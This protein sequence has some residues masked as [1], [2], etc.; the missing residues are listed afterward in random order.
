MKAPQ[1]HDP[2]NSAATP[3][4]TPREDAAPAAALGQPQEPTANAATSAHQPSGPDRHPASAGSD[5]APNDTAAPATAPQFGATA[6]ASASQPPFPTPA[7]ATAPPDRAPTDAAT[8]G[9]LAPP[10]PVPTD[11]A[12]PGAT[13]PEPGASDGASAGQ[14]PSP[15]LA[16]AT[17]PPH[18]APTDAA[19]PGH[20]APPGPVP[21]DPATP[22]AA[23]PDSA[24]SDTTSPIPPV[25]PDD[26]A[27][28]L[29]PD[30]A[31]PEVDALW[32]ALRGAGEV[33][34]GAAA[35]PAADVPLGP[36]LSPIPG[37]AGRTWA[38]RHRD[39]ARHFRALEP[40]FAG[41]AR[42]AHLLACTIVVLRRQPDDAHARALFARITAERGPAVAAAMNLRWLTSVCDTFCDVGTPLERAT[43]LNG[44]LIANL[45]KLAETE[46]RQFAAPR[47]WPPKAMF[48]N[49]GPLFD[50][51]ITYWVGKGE[52]IGN[53]LD[54]A[55]AVLADAN[56]ASPFVAEIIGRLALNDTVLRRMIEV[57]DGRDIPLAP[58][59]RLA[60][61]RAAMKGL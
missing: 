7:P 10:G 43:A 15:T 54:R 27:S 40:E 35:L 28:D 52:M 9:H 49:G 41:R 13:L 6:P 16:P 14:P 8:P 46:R 38:S 58:R 48:N 4:G 60:R 57:N 56:A 11:P 21:T 1:P 47:D 26:P 19:T 18:H 45:V 3:P 5:A 12:P 37:T 17:A 22:G 51:V 20:P 31:S 53:L 30:F 24:V 36:F 59:E 34:T 50:G 2:R 44:T 29:P 32:P 42:I 61:A 23:L 25:A 33:L 55:E 39:L